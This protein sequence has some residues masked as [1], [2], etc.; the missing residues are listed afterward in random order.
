MNC[1]IHVLQLRIWSHRK[2]IISLNYIKH[3]CVVLYNVVSN[4]KF[5]LCL[6]SCIMDDLWLNRNVAM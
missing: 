3:I 2:G 4:T 1:L 6:G 5:P